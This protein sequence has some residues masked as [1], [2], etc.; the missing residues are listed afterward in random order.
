M[1]IRTSKPS[2]E[3]GFCGGI[4]GVCPHCGDGAVVVGGHNVAWGFCKQ[5]RVCWPIG[6]G[7]FRIHS[8]EEREMYRQKIV[9]IDID[10]FAEVKEAFPYDLDLDRPLA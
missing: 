3:V 10:N 6:S 1:I 7:V 5:H 4:F 8:E 2:A 9:E